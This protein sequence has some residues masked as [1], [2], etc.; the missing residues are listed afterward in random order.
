[1]AFF[2]WIL[3]S[4]CSFILFNVNS[5]PLTRPLHNLSGTEPLDLYRTAN[6]IEASDAVGRYAHYAS[7][8][9]AT[10]PITD[11]QKAANENLLVAT[12]KALRGSQQL[13]EKTEVLDVN[14]HSVCVDQNTKEK[15]SRK[16]MRVEELGEDGDCPVR[17]SVKWDW[18]GSTNAATTVWGDANEKK[19]E[20][21]KCRLSMKG[22]DVFAGMQALLDA[23]I[24]Q[25]PL[26]HYMRDAPMLGGKIVVDHSAVKAVRD[27]E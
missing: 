4:F 11:L 17:Q 26:P 10:D 21:F 6:A 25:G 24:L 9:K 22:P 19:N 7:Q 23:G 20:N 16:R 12:A 13:K 2:S 3:S 18:K 27:Q 8:G 1:M 14:E 15:R 5:G